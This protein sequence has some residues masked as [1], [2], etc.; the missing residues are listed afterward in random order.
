MRN[1]ELPLE[2]VCAL[3]SE[4]DIISKQIYKEKLPVKMAPYEDGTFSIEIPLNQD[5]IIEIR[6]D[7]KFKL[8]VSFYQSVDDYDRSLHQ[9]VP[10]KQFV[11]QSVLNLGHYSRGSYILNTSE[12]ISAPAISAMRV[13]LSERRSLIKMCHVSSCYTR[14]G[15]LKKKLLYW[16]TKATLLSIEKKSEGGHIVTGIPK[17][18][19]GIYDALPGIHG[20]NG[21]YAEHTTYFWALTYRVKYLAYEWRVC[22]ILIEDINDYIIGELKPRLGWEK[23]SPQRLERLNKCIKGK[24][25]TVITH[26]MDVAP[27]YRSFYPENS[28]DKWN[29]FLNDCFKDID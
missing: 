8:S 6:L 10:I 22:D 24:Q 2:V 26:D 4:Q 21:T 18:K 19:Q 1:N 9:I 13:L 23:I 3:K 27:G 7:Q 12:S 11:P 29:D 15:Q 20:S 28:N 14:D 16:T 17:S 5:F 25:L